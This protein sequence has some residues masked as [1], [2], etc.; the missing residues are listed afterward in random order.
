MHEYGN[1]GAYENALAH[2]VN[3]YD[4]VHDQPHRHDDPLLH[5]HSGKRFHL[6][7]QHDSDRPQRT[8]PGA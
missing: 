3:A 5:S 4:D 7:I 2:P 6:L 8:H 1:V